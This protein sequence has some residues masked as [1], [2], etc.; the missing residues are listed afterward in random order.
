ML[1]FVYAATAQDRV[2]GAQLLPRE[3]LKVLQ[4]D[5]IKAPRDLLEAGLELQ[6]RAFV[7]GATPSGWPGPN[8]IFSTCKEG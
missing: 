3:A 2:Q 8:L 6:R 5:V 4:V 7:L 1:V